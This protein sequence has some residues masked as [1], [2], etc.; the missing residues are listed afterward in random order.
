MS[1]APLGKIAAE[2]IRRTDLPELPAGVVE[3]FQR[4]SDLTGTISDVVDLLGIKCV[5]PASDLR[6]IH[7][8]QRIVGPALTVRNIRRC[9]EVFKAVTDASN[10]MGETEAHNLAKPGDVLVMEG[11]TGASNMGGQSA[12]IGRRQG[13]IGA[14]IDGSIRDPDQYARMGWPVWCRGFSPI[15]GKWRLETVEINGVV[16][17]AGVQCKPGDLVCADAAGICF[18]PHAAIETVLEMC[19]RFDR[20]D[21]AKQADIDAG[22]PLKELA[23]RKYK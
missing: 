15:T 11:L 14:V 9:A 7:G 16:Q 5:V 6:P 10:T 12:S 2:R 13:E 8:A 18:I 19:E 1:A 23:V 17:I 3:R 21:A 4:L 22:V 20:G